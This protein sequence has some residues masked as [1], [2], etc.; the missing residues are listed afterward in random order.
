MQF[1][2]LFYINDLNGDNF[3][4]FIIFAFVDMRTVTETY[5]VSK[6]IGEMLYF[7]ESDHAIDIRIFLFRD[8]IDSKGYFVLFMHLVVILE[9]ISK[10]LKKL[11]KN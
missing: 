8:V 10:F 2:L 9:F 4:C 11:F 1:V 5:F 7:F 6:S 3:V